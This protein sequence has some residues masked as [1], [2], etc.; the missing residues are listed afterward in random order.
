MC[1]A[2]EPVIRVEGLDGLIELWWVQ[3]DEVIDLHQVILLMACS[4]LLNPLQQAVSLTL[5]S[6]CLQ[7]N[8]G[9][10]RRVRR[11]FTPSCTGFSPLRGS[12]VATGVDHRRK[13]KTTI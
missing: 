11:I 4:V 3:L 7:H 8:F 12:R 10:R 1:D 6:L 13:N 9:Q 2:A 5:V